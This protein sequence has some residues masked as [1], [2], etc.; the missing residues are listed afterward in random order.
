MR[1][2]R[3]FGLLVAALALFVSPVQDLAGQGL[4]TGAIS[5]SVTDPSGKAL[6]NAQLEVVNVATGFKAS[7]LTRT[8]GRYFIQ[9]LE[10]GEYRVTARLL[11]YGPKV[12]VVRVSLNLASRVDFEMVQAATTL[13]AVSVEASA[14]S[15]DFSS[16]RQGIASVIT[17]SLIRRGPSLQRDFTD[18]VK[19]TPQVSSTAQ[20]PSAGGAYNR[21]NNFTVDGANQNDRFNLGSSGGVPG[22]ATSGRIMSMEA[23]KEFQVLMSPTDVRYGNFA[24]MMI[25]AVT[26][27]GTNTWEGG[28]IYMFRSP[29]MAADVEE[30]RSSDFKI[31]Q[32]GFTLGGPIIKDKLHFFVAPE[33]QQRTDPTAGPT[34][35]ADGKKIENAT[36]S[37]S[38]DSINAVASLLAPRFDAGN[39]GVFRRGNPLT[40]LMG[41]VDWAINDMNRFT[42]RVLDNTAEQDEYSRSFTTIRPNAGQQS[43]GM[44]LTSNSFTRQNKNRSFTGQLFS[45]FASGIANELLFGYN[46]VDDIRIVPTAAPEISVGVVQQTT[47]SPSGT[48]PNAVITAGTERLFTWQRAQSENP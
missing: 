25:N 13:A 39:V 36:T 15:A 41:R 10:V 42:F 27:N 11:G 21:L 19:L 12:Q 5:G 31:K 29:S 1:K 34:L 20:G 38:L 7:A 22:G 4:T 33:W 37:I 23:V 16:T 8:N 43:G 44:R 47:T 26:R 17:D 46:T 6:E 24:G 3:W 14:N 32:Y 30:I 35:S 28:G 48:N 40:N 18:L 45:N 2:Q 9:G